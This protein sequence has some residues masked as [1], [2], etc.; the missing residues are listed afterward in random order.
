MELC[1]GETGLGLPVV[2]WL[3]LQQLFAVCACSLGLLPSVLA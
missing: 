1:T 2:D 3:H